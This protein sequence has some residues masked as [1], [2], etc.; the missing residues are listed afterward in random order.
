MSGL[1]RVHPMLWPLQLV[2][3]VATFGA[4]LGWVGFVY[5]VQLLDKR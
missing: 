2:G 5:A 1:Q 4:F 3:A